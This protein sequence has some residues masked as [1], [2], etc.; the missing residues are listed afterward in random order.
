MNSDSHTKLAA[1]ETGWPYATKFYDGFKALSQSE[2][3]S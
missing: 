1:F 3:R 2:V